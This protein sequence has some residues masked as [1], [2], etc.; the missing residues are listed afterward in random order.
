MLYV[1]TDTLIAKL[2]A[3]GATAIDGGKLQYPEQ[4]PAPWAKLKNGKV[5]TVAENEVSETL[6]AHT[7]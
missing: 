3:E 4:V 6:Y 5:L 1:V 2:R 7:R